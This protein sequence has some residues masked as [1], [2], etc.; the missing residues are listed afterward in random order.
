MRITLVNALKDDGE[1]GHAKIITGIGDG[2]EA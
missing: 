2:K 1:F